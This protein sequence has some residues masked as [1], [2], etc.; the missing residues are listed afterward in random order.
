[1]TI[2]IVR[3]LLRATERAF[4]YILYICKA[5]ETCVIN[6]CKPNNIILCFVYVQRTKN[7][8]RL[9]SFSLSQI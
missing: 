9:S 6:K 8:I 3:C 1:M 7:N 4:E 2:K 5:A